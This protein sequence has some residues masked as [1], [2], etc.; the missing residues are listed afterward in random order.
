MAI[1]PLTAGLDLAKTVV[2]TIWPD[3]SAAEQAQLAAAVQLVQGQLEI[4]KVEAGNPSLFVAGP[5]PFIMWVCGFAFAY[6]F[7]LA[8]AAAFTLT[9]LGHP[10][11]LPVLD[12][13]EMSTVLMGL[14]GL[15]GLRT[16][17][18]IKGVA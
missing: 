12:F 17:E 8:P 10:I 6:K 11:V 4:N 7:I 16:V 9:A 5:R 14:L 2:G 15:G 13:T 1:D 3:K 18:K